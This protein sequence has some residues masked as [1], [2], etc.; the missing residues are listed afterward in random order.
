MNIKTKNYM[1]SNIPRK[2]LLIFIVAYKAERTIENV[3]SRIPINLMNQFETFL[4]HYQ[5]T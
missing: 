4:D 5:I 1:K 2:K 3:I